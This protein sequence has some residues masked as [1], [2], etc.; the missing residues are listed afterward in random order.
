MSGGLVPRVAIAV[1]VILFWRLSHVRGFSLR[2]SLYDSFCSLVHVLLC[3]IFL[4]CVGG[5]PKC[6]CEVRS[7]LIR[8]WS[9]SK[10]RAGLGRTLANELRHRLF[11]RMKSICA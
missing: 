7:A 1:S 4:A 2:P 6:Q 5:V 11:V 8:R 9:L 10:S 3:R